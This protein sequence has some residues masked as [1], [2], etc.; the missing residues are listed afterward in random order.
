L[1]ELISRA[2]SVKIQIVESDPYEH[3]LRASLNLGHTIGHAV[4]KASNYTLLHGEAIA[5]GLVAETI[6][7]EEVGIARS[8]LTR[9]LIPVLKGFGLPVFAP[10][11]ISA[12]KI[13]Q[14]IKVDKKKV[15]GAVRFALPVDIGKIETGVEIR[16]LESALEFCSRGMVMARID[17]RLPSHSKEA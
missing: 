16:D 3:G 5:I 10:D 12:E 13:L 6:L 17:G 11:D 14:A 7:A 15:A 4:E 2:I 1:A 9:E 8:G